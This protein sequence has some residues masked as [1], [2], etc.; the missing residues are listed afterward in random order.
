MTIELVLPSTLAGFTIGVPPRD[1]AL[2]NYLMDGDWEDGCASFSRFEPNV[3]VTICDGV[4]VSVNARDEC[5][6]GGIELIGLSPAEVAEHLSLAVVEIE[7][8]WAEFVHMTGG[9]ELIVIEGRV[10]QL[11][12]S[13]W[14]LIQG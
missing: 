14:D 8:G 4:V 13:D 2:R 10:T 9:V 11:A 12:L 6:F 1:E 3:M 7:P 5:W